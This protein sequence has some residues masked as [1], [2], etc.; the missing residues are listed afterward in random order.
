MRNRRSVDETIPPIFCIFVNFY[1][2]L[3][4]WICRF[5]G[6]FDTRCIFGKKSAYGSGN[7]RSRA[8]V[9]EPDSQTKWSE[10]YWLGSVLLGSIPG[11]E[12]SSAGEECLAV[13]AFPAEK[14]LGA[15]HPREQDESVT[16]TGIDLVADDA[17]LCNKCCCLARYWQW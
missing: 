7:I 5:R 14:L 12:A 1:F 8:G 17:V 15:W 10:A 9:T 2:W 4:I 11:S 6:Q 13:V 3:Y 16:S